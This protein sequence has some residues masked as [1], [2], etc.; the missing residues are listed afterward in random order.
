MPG[1]SGIEVCRALREA[2]ETEGMK[3]VMLTARSDDR[4]RLA[5]LE[6]GVDDYITKPFSPVQVLDKV[7]EVLG[8]DALISR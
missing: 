1:K 8:P 5:G 4:D 6:A 7:I 3:I 2:P